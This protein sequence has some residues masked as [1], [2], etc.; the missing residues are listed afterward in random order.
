MRFKKVKLRICFFLLIGVPTMSDAHDIYFCGEKIPI[1]DLLVKEKLMN[2]IKKQINYV[3]FPDLRQRIKMYMP[4]VE[5]YLMQANLPEDFKYLAIVESGFKTDV[6]SRAGARGFWQL[7]IPTARD[8]KLVVNELV[9]ERTDFDK[10]TQ[11]AC[12]EIARNYLSLRKKFNIS[13]WSLTAAAYNVGITRIKNAII[14]QGG[15]YFSMNLNPETAAYVYKIIAVKELFEYP[16]LYMNNFGYNVFNMAPSS[17][18]KKISK[19]YETNTTAF[20]SMKIDI[21]PADG[22]HPADL[23]HNKIKSVAVSDSKIKETYIAARIKGKYKDFKDGE[24]INFELEDNLEVKGR[25][26]KKDN[27]IQGTG[28]I[29]DDKVMVDLGLGHEVLLLDIHME[30]G[31]PLSNLKNKESVILKVISKK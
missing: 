25:F 12:R 31:I 8:W 28:W 30:K 1:D 18:T 29:I 3:N 13:S 4:R 20:K 5:Q 11:A 24:V 17:E 9:D 15:N 26:T 2:I 27:I 22:I 14:K 23:V 6:A 21:N 7:M 19:L 16:E 10:S